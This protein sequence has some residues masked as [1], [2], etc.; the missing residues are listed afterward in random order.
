MGNRPLLVG[1]V[2]RLLFFVIGVAWDH[3]YHIDRIGIRYTD[4]DYDVFSDAAMLASQGNSPYER[5]TYRYPPLLA[6][7]LLPFASISSSSSSIGWHL[8][9]VIFIVADVAIIYLTQLITNSS[10]SV[11]I[12]MSVLNPITIN[13]T[14]RGSADS[15]TNMLILLIIYMIKTKYTSQSRLMLSFAG[16]TYGILIHLRI[17]PIIY[18]V[19]FCCYVSDIEYYN[20]IRKLKRLWNNDLIKEPDLKS[21][22]ISLIMFV[23][24]AMSS[25]IIFSA[26]SYM[27]YGNVYLDNAF[28]YHI[29]RKDH[30]HN[31]SIYF[32]NIYLSYGYEEN[33]GSFF[34]LLPFVP[35][36]VLMIVTALHLARKDLSLCLFVQTMIFVTFNK[37]STAQYFTW[38]MC[39]IPIVFANASDMKYTI[40]N[41]Y[42][43]YIVA[44]WLLA[45]LYWLLTAYCLEILGINLYFSLYFGSFL[46]HIS[47]V[48]FIIYIIVNSSSSIMV[49]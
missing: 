28:Y 43:Y 1:A 25:F 22:I 36:F 5:A 17:Y 21:K 23:I 38:Y 19:A 7:L 34:K 30:R 45:L 40:Y 47:S 18:A 44:F 13:I 20:L 11:W 49:F 6:I 24:T 41:K 27:F 3:Y 15:L 26:T 14:T 12:W 32:Y 31:F 48:L 37:V 42:L 8:G 9:K 4:I 2:I 29:F 39:L 10:S 16:F 46:L 33:Y 35:Q